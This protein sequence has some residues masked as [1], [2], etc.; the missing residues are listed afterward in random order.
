M[1]LVSTSKPVHA[2]DR[3]THP[4]AARLLRDPSLQRPARHHR[5][6]GAGGHH[7]LRRAASVYA[8]GA[9]LPD[10]RPRSRRAG[11]RHLLRMGV[12]NLA[13]GRDGGPRGAARVRECSHYD[14]R[15]E[16]P[17]QGASHQPGWG[18]R[19]DEPRG[20][21]WSR[22]RP[23]AGSRRQRQL[24]GRGIRDPSDAV[25]AAIHPEWRT[26]STN[27]I[28]GTCLPRLWGEPS[29]TMESFIT[30]RSSVSARRSGLR[31]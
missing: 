9:P 30:S 31:E 11:A 25:W 14:S 24:A 29:W 18:R 16:R 27:A 5:R 13:R 4:R 26:P 19:V 28:S 2:A 12:L 20:S 1:I 7:P 6:V 10:P 17:L 3:A 15:R 21:A 8:E 23:V 22:R